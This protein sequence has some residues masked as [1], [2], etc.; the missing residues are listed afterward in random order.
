MQAMMA[1]SSWPQW[2]DMV[3]SSMMKVKDESLA[4]ADDD[5]VD[6]G[7]DLAG[8]GCLDF[9]ILRGLALVRDSEA[10]A[11]VAV[12]REAVSRHQLAGV[13]SGVGSVVDVDG[14]SRGT[15]VVDGVV[16]DDDSLVGSQGD[17]GRTRRPVQSEATLRLVE[18]A[19]IGR[20]EL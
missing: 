7:I 19:G 14:A 6:D 16:G 4:V 8:T 3:I 11:D 1:H 20:A 15:G 2:L 18:A 9:G 12:L 5:A 17:R 10:G 13:H